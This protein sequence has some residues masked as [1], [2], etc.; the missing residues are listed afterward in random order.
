M[1][2]N[3]RCQKS[4]KAPK[5]TQK[6]PKTPKSAKKC[7][8]SQKEPK[9]AK[10]SQKEPKR[11]KK[12]QK[13]PKRAKKSQKHQINDLIFFK[14]LALYEAF[15]KGATTFSIMTFSIMT[16][17]LRGLY[18]ILS[19]SDSQHKRHS[20]WKYFVIILSVIMLSVTFYWLLLCG[21]SICWVSLF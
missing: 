19:I 5:S 3:P 11:A 15:Q 17:S 18:V 4:P 6:H 1:Q 7:Q 8:K 2:G 10:K 21:V 13:E 12:S 9:R 14:R 16:L 20:A